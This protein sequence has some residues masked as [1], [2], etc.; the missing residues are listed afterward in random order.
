ME[1][2]KK[3]NVKKAKDLFHTKFICKECRAEQKRKY[4]RKHI[5]DGKQWGVPHRNRPLFI[6]LALNANKSSK[7]RGELNKVTAEELE[8]YLGYPTMCYLCG[9]EL[10]IDNIVME[11]IKPISKGG[12]NTI[13]NLAYSHQLCNLIKFTYTKEEL[14]NIL[15]KMLNNL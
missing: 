5:E 6:R 11:H 7:K 1:I 4:Y 10:S 2:C 13:D 3:C 9:S 14:K 15:T 12:T 8:N